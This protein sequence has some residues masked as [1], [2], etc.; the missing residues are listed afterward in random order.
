MKKAKFLFALFCLVNSVLL[1]QQTGLSCVIK[2]GKTT[3]KKG[4]VPHI[5]IEIKNNTDST[6]QLVK[7]LDGSEVR[8]RYPYAYFKIEMVNDTSY[9]PALVL[10]CGNYDGIDSDDFVEVKPGGSFDPYKNQTSVY[11]DYAISDKRN[12]ER[13]GKYKITFYYST[14]EPD[15][16]KWIGNSDQSW[17]LY[18]RSGNVIASKKPEYDQ[19]VKLF[20]K[21]PKVELVSNEL[22]IEIK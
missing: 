7:T 12:F 21:V 11:Y 8:W 10:R 6:I 2:S 22:I 19:M 14:N 1:C 18:D 20:S 16:K 9:H 5:S 13:K 15:F 3:Y 4:E 17:R